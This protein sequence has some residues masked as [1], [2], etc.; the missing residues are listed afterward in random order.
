MANTNLEDGVSSSTLREIMLLREL[1][2]RLRSDQRPS[3]VIRCDGIATFYPN[4]PGVDQPPVTDVGGTLKPRKSPNDWSTTFCALS[5]DTEDEDD[6]LESQSDSGNAAWRKTMESFFA[7]GRLY[8]IELYE[9]IVD[10]ESNAIFA[11]LEFCDWGR[12]VELSQK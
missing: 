4:Q 1:A 6:L 8:L 12:L 10:R 9:V 7:E 11:A 2:H 5:D 3:S